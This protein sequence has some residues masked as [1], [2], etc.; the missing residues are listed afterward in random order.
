MRS[1]KTLVAARVRF[2][3]LVLF[4]ALA[5]ASDM[6]YVVTTVAGGVAPVTP[7]P[8]RTAF[9]GSILGGTV[10]LAGN[11]YLST[12]LHC[13]FKVDSAGVLTRFAGTCRPGYSGDGGPALSAQLNSPRGLA[14]D[15]S[16]KLY[17]ADFGNQVV[18]KVLPN[19]FMT[20][21][22]GNGRFESSGD[23][24]P[25]IKAALIN[26]R[27]VA[28]DNAGNLYIGEG[29]G[30]RRV[31]TDGTITN[32]IGNLRPGIAADGRTAIKAQQVDPSWLVVDSSGNVYSPGVAQDV[33][34]ISPAGMVSTVAGGG[35]RGYAGDG[36]PATSAQLSRPYGLALDRNG[37][38]YI[39]DPWNANIRKVSPSGTIT[40]IAGNG[41]R[42]SSG[43]GGPATKAAVTP[44][45]LAI[46]AHGTIYVVADRSL[47]KIATNGTISTVVG[48]A[49]ADSKANAPA[50]GSHLYAPGDLAVDSD[51]NIYLAENHE[52]RVRKFYQPGPITTVAGN[53]TCCESGDGGQATAAQLG[54]YI[55]LALD[56]KGNL[57]ILQS[58]S[59]RIR[60]VSR[61]GTI[62]TIAGT[63]S[64]G[65]SGDGGP[66]TSAKLNYPRGIALDA[67]GNLYIADSI[68]QRIRKV[69]I[70]GTISTVAGNGVIGPGG[71][72]RPAMQAPL[73]YP[74]GVAVDS[75]GNLYIL[76]YGSSPLS[77][78]RKA[79]TAGIISQVA[80]VPHTG[81]IVIDNA[82]R[83]YLATDHSI[84]RLTPEGTPE[85]IAGVGEAGYSG[86]GGP[87]LDA[88]FAGISGMA[89]DRSGRIYISDSSA[90]AVRVL[91]PVQTAKE[92]SS[93]LKVE[94][95]SATGSSRFQIGEEIPLQVS[96]SSDTPNRYLEPCRLFNESNFGFP[97]CRLFNHWSFSIRPA[98]G[99]VDL[100]QEF[101]SGPMTSGGPT[102]DV[103]NR[104]LSTQPVVF[105][106]VLTH[107]FRFDKP[108]DYR[109]RLAMDI[110]LDD[111]S[112]QRNPVPGATIRPHTVSVTPQIVLQIVPAALEW[113]SEIV[114]KGYEAFAGPIPRAS[115]PPSTEFAQNQGARQAFCNLGSAEA[116]RAFA[117]LLVRNGEHH[118]EEEGCLEHTASPAAAIEEMERLLVDPSTAVNAGFFRVLVMLLG[119][120]Q[121]RMSGFPTI[122]QKHVDSQREQ[123]FAA[124]PRKS[125]KAR[126]PSLLTIVGNPPRARGNAYE[127]GYNLPL[128]PAI[129]ASVADNYDRF[130]PQAQDWVLDDAWDNVRSP[131]MLPVVRRR[132]MGGDGQALLHWL[133]LDPL[134]AAAFA[135]TEVVRP[136]PRFSSFYLRLPDESLPAQESQLA[137]N[138][139]KLTDEPDLVRSATLLH[140]YATR[141]VL[142]LVLPFID[143][144][145]AGWPCS[146]QLP[147]LAYLLKVS[148]EDA[149][150]RLAQALTE[151]NHGACRTGTFFSD[152]GVLETGPV[153]EQLALAEIDKGP[154][155]FASDAAAYLRQHGSVAVKP[156]L[157]ERI[158]KW[159]QSYVDSGA[160]QRWN[161]RA[162]TND[163]SALHTLVQAL[164]EAFG[165]AQ[166]WLLTPKESSDLQA[167]LGSETTG[168]IS[169]LFNCG[170]SLSTNRAAAIY[171][172]YG[173]AN[174]EWPRKASPVEYLNPA[175]R[176]HYSINQ[177]RCD[178]MKALK[179]KILQFPAGSSFDF[180]WDFTAAD[181]DDI[182]EIGA[183]LRSHGYRVGNTH[184]WDFLQP[185]PPF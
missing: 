71:N 67:G 112:T 154:Q 30:I 178:D 108:G 145:L 73:A 157:L 38:L 19:G 144:H 97:R 124:L 23:G 48:D 63:G 103:P 118:R 44:S 55:R 106:Y 13:V 147:V 150:P 92:D 1:G 43:D 135:R 22:A 129:I 126:I 25:A 76:E 98:G 54:P 80:N 83:L 24:G 31:S 21:V 128:P 152:L 115:N 62:T 42:G 173:R 17:I 105:S 37:N 81:S 143:A 164:A 165:R 185:D 58:E 51:S 82:D 153:L 172:L 177:Y 86:D 133:E 184:Y 151:V 175:E 32:M 94:L 141:A 162:R 70:D 88:R 169:C 136:V 167:L 46:D 3:V 72:G 4:A 79:S 159:H 156:L 34:R 160:E 69:G 117:K 18:R 87:A 40:T 104:D 14:I 96:L 95:R 180:A 182:I 50:V 155:S 57:Y 65:Y 84:V 39:A 8:A 137:A 149:A 114:R 90:G 52:L 85:T 110:G 134:A 29:F 168:G 35:T 56:T 12:D 78:V 11:V 47:R 132:A 171:A 181:R 120:D 26:P 122:F 41:D 89:I 91:T 15:A 142:P 170:A 102:F 109:V 127:F 146:I 123:L 179:E 16:G 10:D 20:T 125:A 27:S 74:D 7:V 119:R 93:D 33:R 75:E 64:P 59:H 5:A 45:F 116:A 100:S 9:I 77:F 174:K 6:Q 139:V 66:A 49:P 121:S 36:G 60:R 148:P 101:P 140:R 99:W 130:P 107:R 183:F 176:L 61:E 131:L 163:D 158:T 113:Q 28:T 111:E 2:A 166:A 161:Q 138:F 68:N 53:G